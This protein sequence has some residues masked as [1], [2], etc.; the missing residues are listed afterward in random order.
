[1]ATIHVVSVRVRLPG[2]TLT[3]EEGVDLV[4]QALR[5]FGLEAVVMGGA[6]TISN[7]GEHMALARTEGS[8]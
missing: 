3:V 4:H 8:I 2:E 5:D 6:R 1:M 7:L